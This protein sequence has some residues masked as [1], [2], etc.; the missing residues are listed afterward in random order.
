MDYSVSTLSTRPDCQALINIA[1][2]EK[3]NLEYRKT[4][5]SRQHQSA[6]LTSLGIQTELAAVTSELTTLNGIIGN[7]PAG[8]TYYDETV[9]KIK[10][11]EY[12]KFLL[13]QRKTN[14]G[15]IA[16]VEKQYDIACLDHAISETDAFIARLTTRMNELPV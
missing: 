13:E 11:A 5:I 9:V 1:N 2:A 4:G 10:R 3:G 15:P 16:L 7:L 8:T 12:K 14:F 6:S